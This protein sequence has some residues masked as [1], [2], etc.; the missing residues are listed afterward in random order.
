[1]KTNWLVVLIAMVTVPVFGAGAQAGSLSVTHPPSILKV[2]PASGGA[3]PKADTLYISMA[4]GEYEPAQLVV[5]AGRGP[6]REVR[7]SVGK[8]SGPE[9][10][11][12][13]RERITVNPLGY[14]NCKAKS[15]GS[16]LLKGEGGEVPDVLLPDRPMDVAKGR[17]QPY[18]ITVRTLRTD[19]AG[20]YRGT[21]R[22]SAKGGESKEIPL[23]VRVY[24]ITLPVKPHLRTV[25]GLC[26]NHRKI[27]GGRPGQDFDTLMRYSKM[28]LAHRISPQVLGSSYELTGMPPR[29]LKNGA[30]DFSSTDRYLSELV[31]LGLTSFYT[32]AGAGIRAYAE[33]LKKKGWHDLAYVY[34]YDEAAPDKLPRMLNQYSSMRQQVPDAKILQVGWNPTKPLEGLVNIWCPTIDRADTLAL[35]RARERGEETWWYTWGG[36]WHPYPTIC[37]MDYAGIYGRITGW[38]S[39]QYQI[40]GFLYFASDIWDTSKNRAPGGRLSVEEY[41]R[42]N[43][44]NWEPNTYGKTSYG[45][46]RN[47][48]GY[49]LYPGKNNMP[50]ASMR[51]AHIRDGFEDYDLFKEV[52]ALAADAGEAGTYA[53]ELLDF[54]RPFDNPL[55]RSRMKWTK[56]DNFLMRRREEILMI[57]EE[58]RG[59]DEPRLQA[60]RKQTD[61]EALYPLPWDE[62]ER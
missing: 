31:P 29:K 48:G 47:G 30:R 6:L 4:R 45:A 28:M 56:Q 43:Y 22:V 46:P 52:E 49:L 9:E 41:D 40:Q 36:P 19:R 58:L 38:M 34:M 17:R 59:P 33:H 42:A 15:H 61:L 7:V 13:P 44:A 23:V 10:S 50:V 2:L 11:V 54:N 35:H 57:G 51:L 32:H 20:E 53:R 12:L 24:D 25:F 8:L 39:Y 26:T 18:F 60:L 14:I 1:M 16:R 21:V 55:I 62:K 5:H 27:R 37:H 3:G